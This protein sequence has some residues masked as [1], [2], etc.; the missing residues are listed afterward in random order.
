MPFF[1][2]PKMNLDSILNL[3]FQS[4]T[5][6]AY[7]KLMVASSKNGSSPM[8]LRGN[9]SLGEIHLENLEVNWKITV[10]NG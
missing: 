3:A 4:S 6:G 1:E 9:S 2:D 8:E 5:L 7:K 10:F